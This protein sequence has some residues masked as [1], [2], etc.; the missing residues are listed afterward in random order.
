MTV[1]GVSAVSAHQE[2]YSDGI[3]GAGMQDR[4]AAPDYA[5]GYTLGSLDRKVMLRRL[6]GA[7]A[8]WADGLMTEECA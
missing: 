6:D 1:R 4:Q 8:A 3:S 7:F 2:G 5:A